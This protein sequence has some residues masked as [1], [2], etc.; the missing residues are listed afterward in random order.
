MCWVCHQGISP[1]L[2][3]MAT[4]MDCCLDPYGQ[5]C[6]NDFTGTPAVPENGGVTDV[7]IWLNGEQCDLSEGGS[8]DGINKIYFTRA[9]ALGADADPEAEAE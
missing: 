7:A 3:E 2:Y 9:S 5:S 1:T 6:M 4:N 8:Y